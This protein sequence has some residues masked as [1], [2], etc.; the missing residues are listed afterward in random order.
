MMP[1]TISAL[2]S[3]PLQGNGNS[4]RRAIKLLLVATALFALSA[5]AQATDDGI[6]APV[7]RAEVKV[8]S[9]V[10]RVGDVVDN[11][12]AAAQ[13]PIYR[14]PDLG[15]TGTLAVAQ[16]LDVLRARNVIG[17]DAR[18]VRQ[19]QVTRLARTLATKDIEQAIAAA[20]DHRFGLGDAANIGVTIDRGAGDLRLEASSTGALQPGAVRYEPRYGRFDITFEIA[21]SDPANPT[22]LR[23][24]GTAVETVEVAVLTRDIDRTEAL[25]LSDLAVERRPRAEIVGEAAARDRAI[26]MQLRRPMRAGSA[27]KVADL[28]RPDLVQRDQSVT[29]IYKVPGLYLTTRGKALESGTEGD[30]VSV[31]NLQSKR[32]LTGVVTGRGQVSIQAPGAPQ[33]APA[34]DTTSLIAPEQAPAPVALASTQ[35]S[36]APARTE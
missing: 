31:M 20:L 28:A 10:V 30:V 23:F 18:N 17:V 12:G 3:P 32:T 22:R 13:I 1:A 5:P 36:P 25:K 21:G 15:T 6:A 27:L 4:A 16:V 29:I 11:A 33:P 9:D 7:L 14:S 19:V 24:T 35:P 34:G 8:T 26:G 2:L